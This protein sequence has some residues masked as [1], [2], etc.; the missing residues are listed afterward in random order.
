MK[1]LS[2]VVN[3]VI[4]EGMQ[5]MAHLNEHIHMARAYRPVTNKMMP[6]W[7]NLGRAITPYQYMQPVYIPVQRSQKGR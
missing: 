2:R 7:R 6:R 4:A 3:S 1:T 5:L